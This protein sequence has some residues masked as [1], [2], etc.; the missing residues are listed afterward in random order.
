ML[1]SMM[2]GFIPV[3]FYSSMDFG[4]Q[5]TETIFFIDPE[6]EIVEKN[7]KLFCEKVV[8]C[9]SPDFTKPPQGFPIPPLIHFIWLGSPLSN[10]VKEIIESWRQHHPGFTFK[11]WQDQ[12][13]STFSWSKLSSK[14]AFDVAPTFAGKADILRLEILFQE[15]GIYSDTDVICLKPFHDLIVHGSTFFGGLELNQVWEEYGKPLYVGTAVMGAEKMSPV[16]GWCIDTFIPS[17]EK[18]PSPDIILKGGPGLL[19]KSCSRTLNEEML[20]LPCS[21]L[22]PLPYSR[23]KEDFKAFIAPESMAIHL[24]EQSWIFN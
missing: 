3:Y 7:F 5:T 12:E 9:D 4:R 17:L 1:S 21:Y 19:S 23:K 24:W 15:G 20:I 14:K 11:I 8:I 6:M 22:Y 18:G 13:A 16:I 2:E 10:D